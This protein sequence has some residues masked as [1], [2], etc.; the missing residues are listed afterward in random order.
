MSYYL[1]SL[2]G[3]PELWADSELIYKQLQPLVLL[4][5]LER[6]GEKLRLDVANAFWPDLDK[7]DRLA[8]LS[9]SLRLIEHAAPGAVIKLDEDN[10]LKANVSSD[11][12]D[13]TMAIEQEN[14]DFVLEIYRGHYL[15][16]VEQ[17]KRLKLIDT[18]IYDW[19]LAER[20]TMLDMTRAAILDFAEIKAAQEHYDEAAKL[21]LKAYNLKTEQSFLLPQSYQRIYTL[22]CAGQETKTLRTAKEAIQL[23]DEEAITLYDD[24]QA[25]RRQLATANNLPQ[26]SDSL[27]GRQTELEECAALLRGDTR[28]L[29]LIGPPGIGKTAFSKD[30]TR[31]LR[32]YSVFKDGIY[33]LW[34]EQ[35]VCY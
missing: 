33:A 3:R 12:Q 25:A 30:L 5:Y 2:G 27:I 10:K 13:L 7:Q 20:E 9:E 8:R 22:L 1:R 15:Q 32:G 28:L 4:C 14:Y 18:D 29:C 31:N 21:A 17:N 24:F 23:Y 34:L 6:S 19:L 11:V 26:V 35:F 16:S